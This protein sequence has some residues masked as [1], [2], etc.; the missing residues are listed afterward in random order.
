LKASFDNQVTLNESIRRKVHALQTMAQNIVHD[1]NNYYGILQGYLSMLEMKSG[2]DE[3]LRKF[4]PPMKEALQSGIDLNKRLVEFYRL[5]QEMITD[6]DL[7]AAAREVCATFARDQEFTV[8]VI[9][10]GELKPVPLNEAAIR[11][12]VGDLCLLA[13]ETG[14][15]PA[16]LELAPAELEEEA[17]AAMVLESRPGPYLRLRITISLADYP[18]EEETEFLNPF[19]LEQDYSSGLGLALLHNTLQNHGG[20]LD[21]ASQDKYITLNLYFPQ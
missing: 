17:I 15:S 19:A 7:A 4:L 10:S 5:G 2:D 11:S 13:K 21:V 3:N 8:D 12:L 1:T 18:Q 14:T 16:Q 20:N 9:V 6:V